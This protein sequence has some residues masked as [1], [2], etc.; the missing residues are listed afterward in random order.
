MVSVG[1]FEESVDI[2]GKYCGFVRP[3]DIWS[4]S[5]IL[6]VHFH[7]DEYVNEAGF[8]A[9]YRHYDGTFL[10]LEASQQLLNTL[11]KVLCHPSSSPP[12]H[13]HTNQM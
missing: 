7:S 10:V 8:I 9:T 12:P 6:V 4:T 3:A 11:M 13:T 2:I 1:E 5:N